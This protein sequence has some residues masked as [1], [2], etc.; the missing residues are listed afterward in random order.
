MKKDTK[1][2]RIDGVVVRAM[3]SLA[4]GVAKDS[5]EATSWALVHQPKEPNELAKRLASMGMKR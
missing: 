4:R 1:G 5:V 3:A 2:K